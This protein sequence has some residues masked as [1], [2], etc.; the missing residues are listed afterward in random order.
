MRGLNPSYSVLYL[1]SVIHSDIPSLNAEERE[2]IRMSI[3]DKLKSDPVG[4]GVPLRYSF[5][6]HRRLRVGEDLLVIY[7]IEPVEA[8]VIVIALRNIRPK[9]EY[10]KSILA[11]ELKLFKAA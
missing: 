3:E 2:K 4:Y 1:E 7:R 5:Q 6:G 8:R 10:F 9:G 11:R